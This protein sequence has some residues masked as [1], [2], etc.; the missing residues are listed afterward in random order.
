MA[1]PK[2]IKLEN[3]FNQEAGIVVAQQPALPFEIKR[4]YWFYQV[5]DKQTR[6]H[7]AHK[8]NQKILVCNQ[9]KVEVALESATGKVLNFILDKPYEGLH[10]PPMF[11]GT[12]KFGKGATMICLASAI[13]DEKD[14]IRDYKEFKAS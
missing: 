11:W 6:G 9:G 4:V 1:E 5:P 8:T 14:Y 3:I 2:I 13:Y 12:Y 7:H 10:V